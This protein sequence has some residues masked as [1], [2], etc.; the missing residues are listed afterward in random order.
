MEERNPFSTI[1]QLSSSDSIWWFP[2]LRE[3]CLGPPPFY[4]L[5]LDDDLELC[6]KCCSNIFENLTSPITL[7]NA[8]NTTINHVREPRSSYPICRVS[9]LEMVDESSIL[10]MRSVWSNNRLWSAGLYYCFFLLP[11][12][13]LLLRSLPSFSFLAVSSSSL[14]QHH[15]LFAASS[16][17]FF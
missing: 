4:T 5:V 14:L 2:Q 1:F 9:R 12:Y 11:F 10:M 16:F 8:T 15:P 6:L 17:F 7:L 3:N 13:L